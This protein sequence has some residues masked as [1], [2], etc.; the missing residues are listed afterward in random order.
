MKTEQKQEQETTHKNIEEDRKLLIQVRAE[1]T[2]RGGGRVRESNPMECLRVRAGRHCED[3]E[4]EEGPEA[5]AAP[6]RGPEPAVVPVQAQSSRHQGSS[7]FLVGQVTMVTTMSDSCLPLWT[8]M[9]RHPHREGVPGASG[10]REGHVQLPGLN[11]DLPPARLPVHPPAP[12]IFICY[13]LHFLILCLSNNMW[14]PLSGGH[15]VCLR[16]RRHGAADHVTPHL[17][18]RRV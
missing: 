11:S 1:Q 2:T 13:P 8:E 15:V 7:L 6:G 5:P 16:E 10:R 3:H 9:H 14:V 18:A 12:F 4:D 17:R